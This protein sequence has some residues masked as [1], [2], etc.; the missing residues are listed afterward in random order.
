MSRPFPARRIPARI[1]ANLDVFDF[2]LTD[3]EMKRIAALKRPD[4]RI[5]EPG[6]TRAA[7]GLT[8]SWS[9]MPTPQLSRLRHMTF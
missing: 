2:T 4:G 7:V 5:A 9:A 1:A 6:R 8:A 3:D